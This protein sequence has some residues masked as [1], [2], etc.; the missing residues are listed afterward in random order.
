[1]MIYRAGALVLLAGLAQARVNLREAGD[2]LRQRANP[3]SKSGGE[4]K[5][6]SERKPAPSPQGAPIPNIDVLS[7]GVNFLRV[8][9]A[10]GIIDSLGSPIIKFSDTQVWTTDTRHMVPNNTHV[11]VDGRCTANTVATDTTSIEEYR[12]TITKSIGLYVG[13]GP[14]TGSLSKTVT[15]QTIRYQRDET[16]TW[17]AEGLCNWFKISWM[18]GPFMQPTSTMQYYMDYLKMDP[19]DDEVWQDFFDTV[20][21][22]YWQDITL[23]GLLMQDSSLTTRNQ[24]TVKSH[25]VDGR[26]QVKLQLGISIGLIADK[27]AKTED[28]DIW[29]QNAEIGTVMNVGG[30]PSKANKYWDWVDTVGDKPEPIGGNLKPMKSLFVMW[31]APELAMAYDDQLRKWF[32]LQTSTYETTIPTL[33]PFPTDLALGPRGKY[34]NPSTAKCIEKGSVVLA[35]GCTT[36]PGDNSPYVDTGTCDGTSASPCQ[37]GTHPWMLRASMP[38]D[39]NEDG[40]M[41]NW[42]CHAGEDHG[43]CVYERSAMAQAVCGQ[44]EVGLAFGT[45]KMDVKHVDCMSLGVH[46]DDHKYKS[47]CTATCPVGYYVTGGGCW[48]DD[49]YT[50]DKTQHPWRIT[51][52]RPSDTKDGWYCQ[53]A[54]DNG[55]GD[56]YS[57]RVTKG[58]AICAKWTHDVEGMPDIPRQYEIKKQESGKGAKFAASQKL[59]CGEGMFALG[60]GAEASPTT[61]NKPYNDWA[62]RMTAPLQGAGWG[63]MAGEDYHSNTYYNSVMN[64]LICV[65]FL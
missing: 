8:N 41:N 47:S 42:E 4:N 18:P 2:L 46:D 48:T 21:T 60:G 50:G 35:G 34:L 30:D 55:S 59:Y 19:T 63:S 15:D 16:Q 12:K 28:F 58:R 9:T 52:T 6:G 23:G 27:D 29:T 7:M 5:V 38:T 3:G 65:A 14:I 22:H 45:I 53:M 61:S 40:I 51:A 10:E 17:H 43:S 44:T 57:Y 20:G 54:H 24:T 33:V 31:G 56:K 36:F 1:M 25:D 62:V 49:I 64:Y 13:Y 11:M 37:R 32:L 26:A 39:E